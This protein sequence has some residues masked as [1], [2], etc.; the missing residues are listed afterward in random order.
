[1]R[2]LSTVLAPSVHGRTSECPFPLDRS[3]HN[4]RLLRVLPRGSNGD[5]RFEWH[6]N[7][8]LED[9]CYPPYT[10]LSY[11]CGS[12]RLS[13][14]P[15][16]INNKPIHVRCNLYYFL[17]ELVKHHLE[18]PA[19]IWVDS[20]CIEQNI[21]ERNHQVQN[22]KNTFARAQRVLAWIGPPDTAAKA[23]FQELQSSGSWPSLD[24]EP[25]VQICSRTYWSRMWM[26]QEVCLAKQ[27]QIVCGRFAVSWTKWKEVLR[28]I[29]DINGHD[30]VN[31]W[32]TPAGVLASFSDHF[33]GSVLNTDLAEHVLTFRHFK[34]SVTHDK[35]YALLGL[36]PDTSVLKVDYDRS[37]DDLLLNLLGG[38][39]RKQA[40]P[41]LQSLA[42]ALDISLSSFQ[43]RLELR[44]TARDQRW[45]HNAPASPANGSAKQDF[46]VDA[47]LAMFLLGLY[48]CI[49]SDDPFS[50]QEP[51]LK[52]S[53]ELV[54]SLDACAVYCCRCILCQDAEA[55]TRPPPLSKTSTAF[56]PPTRYQIHEIVGGDVAL[57]FWDGHYVATYALLSPQSPVPAIT[58]DT[59][60]NKSVRP[61]ILFRDRHL[62]R[63]PNRC[64]LTSSSS[65]AILSMPFISVCNMIMHQNQP[66][67]RLRK[68]EREQH[69][70]GHV[71]M[72][73]RRQAEARSID[74]GH[75][76]SANGKLRLKAL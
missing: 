57:L 69:Y 50:R 19:L 22:M 18:L 67:K 32:N 42:Q 28:D 37:I 38:T 2:S 16:F 53:E 65:S 13:K 8:L 70:L 68:L 6:Q 43:L 52:L 20:L 56:V 3:R 4:I 47:A 9:N 12:S 27:L 64:S 45:F 11:E 25:V 62:A 40:L 14:I 55:M 76:D 36:V 31:I 33:H 44:L 75:W 24:S 60:Q 26:V 1:M 63:Y 15:I 17:R 29:G 54:E 7:A 34:C 59:V 23:V 58:H 21:E 10:A 74:A 30:E 35:V 71:T 51:I 73:A 41:P 5:I 72:E 48:P 39:P 61:C 66:L 46:A 49:S